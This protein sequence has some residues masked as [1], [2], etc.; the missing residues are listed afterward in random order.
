M[1]DLDGK[2]SLVFKW[3]IIQIK[4]KIEISKK[5]TVFSGKVI[6][7]SNALGR[8]IIITIINARRLVFDFRIVINLFNV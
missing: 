8:A 1:M 5:R 6:R 3:D 7:P 4:E 2:S